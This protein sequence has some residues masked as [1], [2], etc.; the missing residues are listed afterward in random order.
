MAADVDAYL[1]DR[2]VHHTEGCHSRNVLVHL[3]AIAELVD[4]RNF[5]GLVDGRFV[6]H[7][8]LCSE[9]ILGSKIELT[10]FVV[11]TYDRSKTY[12]RLVTQ[13]IDTV[14]IFIQ[15]TEALLGFY[16]LGLCGNQVSRNGNSGILILLD[17]SIHLIQIVVY[18]IS[19]VLQE[20]AEVN[21]AVGCLHLD[22]AQLCLVGSIAIKHA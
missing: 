22:V 17:T 7:A 15:L 11:D 6:L 21:I 16:Q 13:Q 5:A 19:R 14:S 18:R 3:L 9:L 4:G 20:A 1:F 10:N 8:N 12:T 2:T